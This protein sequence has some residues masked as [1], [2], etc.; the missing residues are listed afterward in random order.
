MRTAAYHHFAAYAQARRGG[1]ISRTFPQMFWNIPVDLRRDVGIPDLNVDL[2]FRPAS[3]D[4]E[5]YGYFYDWLLVRAR[6]E[7]ERRIEAI[8]VFPY[9][10]VYRDPPWRLYRSRGD[11]D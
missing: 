4:Y 2:E 8:E 11:V 7:Q 10:L 6:P 3:F 1:L 9:E 5:S